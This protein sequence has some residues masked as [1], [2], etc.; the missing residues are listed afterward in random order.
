MIALAYGDDHS[1]R[2]GRD[3][4]VRLTTSELIE[5][6]HEDAEVD[7]RFPPPPPTTH[8]VARLDGAGKRYGDFAVFSGFDFEVTKGEKI[9][10]VGPNGSG[11]STFCRLITGEEKPTTG[12]L[13]LG[14]KT[15]PSFF[16]QNHADELDP[17]LTVL[18]TVE[19]VAARGISLP[20][21]DILGCFLF[22][23]CGKV[24]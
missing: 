16:N 7:F 4:L 3:S 5:L 21:R 11:K 24:G 2:V 17:D 13:E 9:A 12:S 20:V 10:V 18:E 14:P 8:L 1:L 22:R 15:L 19:K 6:E 23:S